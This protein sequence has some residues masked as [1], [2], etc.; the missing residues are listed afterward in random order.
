MT[1]IVLAGLVFVAVVLSI[2][3]WRLGMYG[4]VAVALLVDPL[5]KMAPGAPSY[6]MLATAPV[7]VCIAVGA[8]RGND[9]LGREFRATHPALSRL[10]GIYLFTL[11]VP[12]ALSLTYAPGSWRYTLAGAYM[13]FCMLGGIL[14]GFGFPQR[15]GDIAGLMKWYCVLAALMMIGA[16]LERWSVQGPAGLI[17]TS[18]LGTY[19]VT[20]RT[21]A[22]LPMISGFFR[23]PDV[24]G[25]HAATLVMFGVTLALRSVRWGRVGWAAL[26]GWGLV[27]LMFCARR[28]M[29][30][31]VPV[32]GIAMAMLYV[33]LGHARQLT[34]VLLVV[35]IMAGVGAYVYLSVGASADVEKFYSTT[36]GEL[37][38][39]V[40][41]HGLTAVID[42]IREAG[43]FG[44][45]MGMAVP[46][47]HNIDGIRPRIWQ[48]SGPSM[49]AAE[50]GVPG[51]VAFGLLLLGLG[52][53]GFRALRQAAPASEHAVFF[54]VAAV[55][56]AN[57]AAAVVSS[58]I[59]GDPFIGCFLPFMMGVV[60]SGARLQPVQET[61]MPSDMLQST[62]AEP[63]P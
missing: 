36:V 52:A 54:G 39:R 29:V 1:G 31:M 57:V 12:A 16:P 37:D 6:M 28:K 5:R 2:G 63:G 45:G 8:W 42:T 59:F 17:G 19:W 58:Q 25:W 53:S 22:A 11:A 43:L 48:E 10:I 38:A 14:I 50:L 4:L 15:V 23:S 32:F 35:G 27:A 44:Y 61:V 49:I 3:R 18:S 30:A 33:V 34:R 46:G 20:H 60:L 24:Q 41:Q 7:W 13:Q 62:H 47:T 9:W 55:V 56:A 51:L 21:G 26:A 40:Q